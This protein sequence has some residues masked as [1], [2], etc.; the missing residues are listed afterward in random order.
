MDNRR[1][2][3]VDRYLQRIRYDGSRTPDEETLRAIHRQHMLTVPFE[4]FDVGQR[5]IVLDEAAFVRKVVEEWRGGFCYEL[6]GAFAAMLRALGYRVQLLSAGVARDG[7]GFGPDFDHMTLLVSIDGKKWLADVGFGDS[8]VEPLRFEIDTNQLDPAGVFRIS[9]EPASGMFELQRLDKD[10][11]RDQY[12]FTAA[13]RELVEYEEMCR[14]HQTSPKSSFTQKK[15]CSLATE[16]GRMTLSDRR[17][18][19]TSEGH[20][21]ERELSE[22][23]YQ[24]C[25]REQFGVVL[26]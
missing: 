23:E 13:P 18:I 16:T 5:P 3:D 26:T 14:Y 22:P 19:V 20:R 6:N 7:G 8:F 1:I 25:L 9:S 4:N 17:L 12:R 21:D 2:L 10:T 11:W 15:V 24:A